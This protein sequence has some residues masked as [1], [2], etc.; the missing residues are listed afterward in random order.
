MDRIIEVKV[1]GN[2][3]SKDNKNAGVRGEANVAKLRITFDEGWNG[4]TKKVTFWNARGLNPVEITLLPTLAENETTY[5]VPIPAEPMKEAGMLTFVIEGT[6]DDKVQRSL[7]D[8][9]EIKDAPIAPNAGQPVPPTKDELTQLEGEIEKIKGDILEV[10]GAKVETKTYRDEA[11]KKAA[12]AKQSAIKAENAVGKASYIGDNGNW[13]IYDVEQKT[14]VDSGVNSHGIQGERGE[15]GDTGNNGA[16]GYTPVRGVDYWTTADKQ[17]ITKAIKEPK[18][19]LPDV[20]SEEYT[21]L[22]NDNTYIGEDGKSIALGTAANGRITI[23]PSYTEVYFPVD[24]KL[25]E[26]VGQK[27][28][29]SITIQDCGGY[30]HIENIGLGSVDT[31]HN[32]NFKI[33]DTDYAFPI[34]NGTVL[35]RTIDIPSDALEKVEGWGGNDGRIA[36]FINYGG[37]S[38]TGSIV[39]SVSVVVESITEGEWLVWDVAEQKYVPSGVIAKGVPGNDGYTPQKGVDYWTDADKAEIKSDVQPY[40]ATLGIDEVTNTVTDPLKHDGEEITKDELY[41][42]HTAGRTVM[43]I[44]N[45]SVLY[46]LIHAASTQLSF[47]SVNLAT[48]EKLT[49]TSGGWTYGVSYHQEEKYRIGSVNFNP[50]DYRDYTGNF[51]YPSTK[52]MVEYVEGITGNIETALNNIIAIQNNLMGVSK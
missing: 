2:Y 5:L 8:T 16:D 29:Y 3:I 10:K 6:V 50:D 43:L 46:T 49:V 32:K 44:V 48:V 51:Y 30:D 40:V 13:F 45:N 21:C 38:G 17:E 41:N 22:A 39:V 47:S 33:T 20:S 25:S 31:H 36:P 42:A 52:C 19:A 37:W 4:Y 34:T 35:T 14:Y 7:S 15:K 11:E 26:V 27:I 28:T 12:E 1:G 24:I 18:L 23:D 9:L